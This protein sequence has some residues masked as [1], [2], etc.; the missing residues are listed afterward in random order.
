MALGKM[1]QL[2]ASAAERLSPVAVNPTL[3]SRL[4]SPRGTCS[5]CLEVCP[6]KGI[7]ISHREL[8]LTESC[9]S[10]GLCAGVCPT[11]ALSLQEPTESMLLDSLTERA[12]QGK[13]VT[14]TC[15]K[16]GAASQGVHTVPCLGS[17]SL[18]FLMALDRL[19]QPAQLVYKEEVCA[20]CELQGIPL[21]KEKLRQG[22][23]MAADLELSQGRIRCTA[24]AP[25]LK[26]ERGQAREEVLDS[27]R[28]M[29][30]FSV[31]H[32]AKKLPAAV[33]SYLFESE[34]KNG[35]PQAVSV[36]HSHALLGIALAE[37]KEENK[38]R[39][40]AQFS[41]PH[42]AGS[43]YFCNA[44]AL[45]CPLGA[46]QLSREGKSLL[47]LHDPRR[48]S[49]CGL[50]SAVCGFDA[51]KQVPLQ[52]RDLRSG[53]RRVLFKGQEKQCAGCDEII[54]GDD[55]I[56]YCPSCQRQEILGERS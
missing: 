8:E 27:Q 7:R 39:E 18:P 3:C 36:S 2:I 22:R 14:I 49:G 15:N 16:Q 33:T 6:L 51:L 55:T 12:Q 42:A 41:K 31:F 40:L 5:R 37:V 35:G 4:R 29:F 47:L 23:E 52:V 24:T 46:L 53:E 54:Q 32:L 11:G 20:G 25:Q 50:C 28:R 1:D 34:G 26:A 44:C 21:L 10:C 17:L 45:L 38:D 56:R 9:K 13:S 43:C 30:L 19:P 48:C